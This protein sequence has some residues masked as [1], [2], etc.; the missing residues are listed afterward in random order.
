M[1]ERIEAEEC[2]VSCLLTDWTSMEK[3]YGMLSP[4]MFDE[5][6]FGAIF[7]E[8]HNAF[9]EN[10]ELTLSELQQLLEKDGYKDY[11]IEDALT[12]AVSRRTL[13]WQISGHANAILKH[14][15]KTCVDNIIGHIEIMEGDVDNQI[16]GLITDL[17]SL[18]TGSTSKGRT[19]ADI[20]NSHA[21][22]YFCDKEK[23][24]ILLDDEGIDTMTGG[25]QGGDLILCGARPGTGKSALAMQWAW[26][27][28]KQGY[29]VGYYNCEMQ[30]EAVLERLISSKTGIPTTRV[31]LAKAFLNDEEQKYRKAVE[32]LSK[33]DR[34]IIFTGSKNVSDI[35]ADMR[36]HKFDVIII[37]Y[38]QLLFTGSRY[39]GN[40]VAEVGELSRDIKCLAMDFDIPVIALSQ[41]SRATEG[42]ST[43]EP[44]LSDLRESGS[45]EQDASI[46]FFLWDKDEEDR[47][48]KGFKTAKSRNGLVGRYDLVFNGASMTFKP[49]SKVT[50]FDGR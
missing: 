24:I 26:V 1:Y 14:W 7:N 32:E 40:R 11:E 22:D 48:Q 28:A 18:R 13:S 37:D 27:F 49:E 15:K 25:F 16:E 34:I 20:V 21:D 10:K 9:D 33:Q 41:L 3:I 46:V 4:D 42:R 23:N 8:Y 2:L 35:R 30:E 47:S 17:E 19:V 50:P 44:Q 5:A 29:K 36:E 12:R 39:Q 31:R 38:L 45:L 43:K 6:V